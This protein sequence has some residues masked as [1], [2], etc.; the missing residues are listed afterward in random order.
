MG[1]GNKLVR[2]CNADPV[3]SN[4]SI[5]VESCFVVFASPGHFL[6]C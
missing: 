2:D 3:Y 1:F 4:T 5:S 6:Q